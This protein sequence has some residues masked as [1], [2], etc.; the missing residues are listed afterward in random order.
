MLNISPE[1]SVLVI[2]S[3]VWRCQVL[4]TCISELLT[5]VTVVTRT[6]PDVKGDFHIYLISEE[7]PGE[8][9]A[10]SMVR[11]ARERHPE[12]LIIT[13]TGPL[14]AD[15]LKALLTAGCDRVGDRESPADVSLAMRAMSQFTTTLR[16]NGKRRPRGPQNILRAT[17]EM[18]RN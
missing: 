12:A 6:H 14:E 9:H 2:D 17:A 5:D 15:E 3:D 8:L 10:A 4:E 7:F 11:I 1:I 16:Q 13:L 18:I